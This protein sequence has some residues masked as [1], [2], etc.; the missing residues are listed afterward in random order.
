[1][2]I[3]WMNINLHLEEQ[4]ATG[5]WAWPQVFDGNRKCSCS[6]PVEEVL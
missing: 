6:W 5:L 1:M 4:T 3:I 2:A